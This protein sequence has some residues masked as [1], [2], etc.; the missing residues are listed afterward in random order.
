MRR[1]LMLEHYCLRNNGR[2]SWECFVSTSDFGHEI[3]G[4]IIQSFG[5][6]RNVRRLRQLGTILLM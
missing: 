5:P 4:P 1:R 3:L 6:T 2:M